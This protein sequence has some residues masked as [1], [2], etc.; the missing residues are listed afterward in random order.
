M[1]DTATRTLDSSGSRLRR[2]RRVLALAA[3]IGLSPATYYLLIAAGCTSYRAL[4]CS[5][6]V[7]GIWA[8]GIAAAR[9]KADGVAVFVFLLNA[10]GLVL[11]VLGGDER[12]MLAKDPITSAVISVLLAGSCLLGRPAMFAVSRRMHALGPDSAA[13]WETLWYNDSDVRHTFTTATVVWSAGLAADAVVRLLL[14]YSLPVSASVALMNPVQWAIIAALGF[15]TVRSRRRLDVKA[16]L[17]AL[18]DAE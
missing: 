18:P 17:R 15:Y 7:A 12:M 16:R 6:V 14:I 13:R 5:T 2:A 11:A 8:L 1:P 3:D 9:R 10:L 4:V